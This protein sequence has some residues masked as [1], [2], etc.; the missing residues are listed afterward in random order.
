M[1]LFGSA[2]TALSKIDLLIMMLSEL[3]IIPTAT[4]L[5]IKF[6]GNDESV[7]K[8]EQFHVLALIPRIAILGII[9][10]TLY[11]LFGYFVLWQFEEARIFYEYL[12]NTESFTFIGSLM[13]IPPFTYFFQFIRG[14]MF[15]SFLI[16]L[17]F[18]LHG[19]GRKIFITAVWLIYLT[20]TVP[21]II[22]NP[23]FPDIVRWA[24]LIEMVSSMS[25]FGIITGLI[26]YI[27]AKR[28][29]GE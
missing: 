10:M 18:M 28:K 17:L 12:G 9:Y 29:V 20:T 24:H 3:L 15:S 5:S 2:F 14:I 25:L 23:L 8:D 6:F 1:F 13:I 26:L 21:L 4:L 22:P 27:P 7:R 11:I 19:K 16:P